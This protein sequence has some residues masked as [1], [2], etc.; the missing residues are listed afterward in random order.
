LVVLFVT[1]N[2]VEAARGS[3]G[4]SRPAGPGVSRGPG[5]PGG[6]SGRGIYGGFH[7][8]GGVYRP[9]VYGAYP[10]P[11]GFVP[12]VIIGGALGWSLWPYYYPSYYYYPPPPDYYYPPPDQSSPLPPP[13]SEGSAAKLFIY[14]RQ[15]Q[16]EEQKARD[17]EKCHEWAV[18][19]TSFDPTK[20]LVG[21][22]NAQ[23]IQKNG[24]YFRAI[25][26][27]LDVQGYTLR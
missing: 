14:P 12:G 20:P 23:I 2:Q 1:S 17:V 7:G 25:G 3:G 16:S 24:E 4:S 18:G 9:E 21:V 26:A 22:P 15:G 13:A 11:R 19:Q 27:C 10:G 5:G 8:R 6:Y